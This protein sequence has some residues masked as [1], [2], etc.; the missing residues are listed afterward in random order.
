MAVATCDFISA[1]IFFIVA[2]FPLCLDHDMNPQ[3]DHPLICNSSRVPYGASDND[4]NRS[5]NNVDN[6]IVAIL[7]EREE[8]LDCLLDVVLDDDDD[9]LLDDS[10]LLDEDDLLDDDD[11]LL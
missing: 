8:E 3:N 6:R 9:D 1:G 2:S 7:P 5:E 4:S 10:D 11:D